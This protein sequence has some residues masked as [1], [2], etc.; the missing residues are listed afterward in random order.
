MEDASKEVASENLNAANSPAP[1]MIVTNGVDTQA[2]AQ[3]QDPASISAGSTVAELPA[4]TDTSIEHELHDA[5]YQ[6]VQTATV[7][8]QHLLTGMENST[9]AM[10][11]H[12]S[13]A[14]VHLSD[15]IKQI[16]SKE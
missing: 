10:L 12:L 14:L 7:R 15:H 2:A 1:Q 4:A 3:A 8:F 11:K 13:D 16:E 5:L 9:A 6:Y